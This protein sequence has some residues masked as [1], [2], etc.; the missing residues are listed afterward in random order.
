MSGAYLRVLRHNKW[1]NVEVEHLTK[2]E[3]IDKFSQRPAEELVNWISM[4]CEIVKANETILQELENEG[5]I[6]KITKEEFINIAANDT[7]S[8]KQDSP[9]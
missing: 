6:K 4:L 8:R 5:L 3:L 7:P 2:Q 9:F 1:E